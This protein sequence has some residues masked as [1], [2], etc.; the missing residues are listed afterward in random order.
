M[1]T[2][3]LFA[4]IGRLAG[5]DRAVGY[6]ILARGWGA[7]SGVVT[8]AL[9]VRFLTS[10]EQGYYSTFGSIMGIQIFFELGLGLVLMQFASHERAGLEW[11]PQRTLEGDPVAK[12]RLASLLRRGL[13]WYAVMAVIVLAVIYPVGVVFFRFFHYQQAGAP[14]VAWQGPWLFLSVAVAG[15]LLFTP[16]WA[17]LE[18]CGL[19]AE[20]V[21]AQFVGSLVN[22]LL[23]WLMLLQ[24]WGLYA[25]SI[26]GIASTTWVIGWLLVRQRGFLR[27]LLR[28]ARPHI[29]V[30][31]RH[32]IWP[33]Q[34]KIAVSWLSGYF[35]TQT[36]VPLLFAFHSPVWAGR[37]G[38]SL[39]ITSAIAAISLSWVSTKAAPF[40]RLVAQRDWAQMDRMFFPALWRSTLALVVGE[41]G[42]WL[43]TLV[44]HHHPF[45][46]RLSARLLDPVPLGLLMGAVVCAHIVGAESIYLR[47]HKQEPFLA[48][49]LT[50][51]GLT[52]LGSWFLGKPFGVTGMMAW[53]LAVSVGVG[54]GL[55]NWIFIQKR[56]QWHA[57]PPPDPPGS[58]PLKGRPPV[59]EPSLR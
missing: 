12:A 47:A 17:T 44:L 53:Y 6:A 24:H 58:T 39:S 20:V 3:L 52:A 29:E 5:V 46:H 25:A 32:E 59:Q 30:S 28:A 45:A 33:L 35:I 40:G 57:D 54:L 48:L 1:K 15:G 26:G 22:S 10:F 23:F 37:M 2:P 34:W 18:G 49:S 14:P 38:L 43:L 42:F 50:V 9:L 19:V 8:L 16:L 55:G 21:A 51:G 4:K 41:A 36:F 7:L 13:I 27:D 11:S 31:W 56:R